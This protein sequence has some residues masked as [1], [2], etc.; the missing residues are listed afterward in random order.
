MSNSATPWTKA[1]QASL[2]FIISRSLLKL[3]MPSNH[4]IL[5]HPLL[6]LPSI[7]PSI[8]VFPNESVLP[9]RWAEYW[10]SHSGLIF[11]RTEPIL[12][13]FL[14]SLFELVAMLSLFHGVFVCL[15]VWF[16]PW[17]IWD[18][19]SP[20]RDQTHTTCT[21]RLTNRLPGKSLFL[22][23]FFYAWYLTMEK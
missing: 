8:R 13:S 23:F 3:M 17:G 16:W 14:K 4:L 2:S 20:T 5:C 12:L 7:F 1:C 11:F 9:I 21:R 22:I 15:I 6:L 19:N 18:L 10:K